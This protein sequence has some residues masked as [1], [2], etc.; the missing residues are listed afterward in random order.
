MRDLRSGEIT[1]AVPGETS[2]GGVTVQTCINAA[3]GPCHFDHS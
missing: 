3:A 1:T 2:P